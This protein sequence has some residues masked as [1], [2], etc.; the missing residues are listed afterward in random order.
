MEPELPGRIVAALDARFTFVVGKGGVGKTTTAGALALRMADEGRPT[1]LLSTDPAHS[2][3]DVFDVDLEPSGEAADVCG[4]P[5]ALEAFDAAGYAESWIGE[6][7]GPLSELFDLGTYLD[8]QDV[9]SFLGLSLPGLDEVM[10][11]L[12]LGDLAESGGDARVVVDTAPTGHTL[13]LLDSG[14]VLS[15]WVRALRAMSRKATAVAEG[16]TR[17]RVRLAADAFVDELAADVRRFEEEV[18]AGA[19]FVVVTRGDPLVRDETRRL[20][21]ELDGRGLRRRV[22]VVVPDGP[23]RGA[24]E[25]DGETTFG[26]GW[27]PDLRGCAELRRWGAEPAPGGEGREGRLRGPPTATDP[28]RRTP[29]RPLPELR[30]LLERR[31]LLFA[32]KGGVGKSTC[33][34]ACAV[35]SAEARPVTLISTDPAGSL[36]ALLEAPLPDEDGEVVPGLEVRQLDAESEL[37]RFLERSRAEVERI[38]EGLGVAGDAA[39]DREVAESLLELAPPGVDEIFALVRV[40]EVVEEGTRSVVVDAAP[41][42]H[43]LRLIRMPELALDWIHALMRVLL[44][45]RS[46][47]GLEETGGRLLELARRIRRLRALLTDP[48]RSA[49]VLVTLAGPVVAAESRRLHERLVAAGIPVGAWVRNR[50]APGAGPARPEVAGGAALRFA[51]PELHE[52]PRGA[53]ALRAFA[54]RWEVVS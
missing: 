17:G 54:S 25:A 46:V 44:K 24:P 19:R 53:R 42:G 23:G 39:L 4:A 52:P 16:L 1:R 34:A 18:L 41:T 43:F 32:G 36:E 40:M 29:S 31:V 37:D 13:R 51:A 15:T 12:R 50:A 8:D 33:A 27:Q 20:E 48:D 38:F 28:E 2:L 9:D 35:V 47:A 26:V 30:S 10:A 45:Y 11:A 7:S 5:L 6:A 14:R 49:A 21:A 22:R 3:G